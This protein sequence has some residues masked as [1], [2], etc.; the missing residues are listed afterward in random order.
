MKSIKYVIIVIA[1][2]AG[3]YGI[4]YAATR[5][6]AE[7]EIIIHPSTKA[8]KYIAKEIDDKIKGCPDSRFCKLQRDSILKD[9]DLLLKSQQTDKKTYTNYLESA[10]RNKFVRQAD[11][12]FSHN[13]WNASDIKLI[14]SETKRLEAMFEGNQQLRDINSVLNQYNALLAFNERVK[15]ACR[16]RPLC[17][18]NN[19]YFYHSDNWNV[20]ETNSILAN[21]PQYSGKVTNA[22]VYASTRESSVRSRLQEAHKKFIDSKMEAS[23]KEAESWNYDES[24]LN[25][26]NTMS[27]LLRTECFNSYNRLWGLSTHDWQDVLIELERFAH[28][29]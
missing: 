21:I 28:E 16:Q 5:E 20:D 7:G 13:K 11:Y 17:L 9:I 23:S 8:Q 24:K 10:Y 4:Y 19:F 15:K 14:R 6:K 18:S 25:D 3:A 2:M 1:L 12:V 22:P 29:M 27:R 26:Y